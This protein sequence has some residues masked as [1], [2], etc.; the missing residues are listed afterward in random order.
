MIVSSAIAN[1]QLSAEELELLSTLPNRT[2]MAIGLIDNGEVQKMGWVN[3]KG[4]LSPIQNSE[5]L[6]EAGSITK[7]FTTL[8]TLIVL[9]ENQ[10]NIDD[11]AYDYYPD[12]EIKGSNQITFRQLMTHTSGLPKMPKNFKWSALRNP[13]NPVKNYKEKKV[14]KYLKDFEQ[15]EDRGY[16]YSNVGMGSLG[17]I[18]ANIAKEDLSTLMKQEVFTP[19][20]MT[21]TTLGITPNQYAQVAGNTGS[22]KTPRHTWIFTDV[23]EGAGNLYSN[24]DD[25]LKFITFALSSESNHKLMPILKQME[26]P[27]AKMSRTKSIGLGIKMAE[28]TSTIYYH[29]GITYGYKSLLAYNQDTQKGIII[30]TKVKGLSLNENIILTKVGFS[31]LSRRH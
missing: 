14:N 5:S 6:F 13:S 3:K 4:V 31:Y 29:G 20:G 12:E 22:Q 17:F 1:S 15:P 8:T 18:A 19:L 24:V 23:T 2:E 28:R 26:A 9:E 25:L 11:R 16:Q 30:L 7:I 21:S 27:Q 10:I